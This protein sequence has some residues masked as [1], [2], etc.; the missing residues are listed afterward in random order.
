MPDIVVNNSF[1]ERNMGHGVS[2][3]YMRSLVLI[4]QSN[5]TDN[6]FGSGLNVRGGA[7]DINV[8]YS[9]I[10][11]NIGDGVNITYE[12][13]IQ[14]V[15]RS[16]ISNNQGRGIAIWFNETGQD[17]K[18]TH[19]TSVAYS[20]F[21]GNLDIGLL[22]GNFCRENFVNVSTNTFE[23]SQQAAL[24]LE[25]CWL[26]DKPIRNAHIGHN[27]FLRNQRLAISVSPAV[28]M[29]LTI[30]W[31]E[32]HE[33]RRGTLK[34]FNEDLN[35]LEILPLK[36][37][38]TENTFMYNT[39]LYVMLLTLNIRALDQHLLAT[40]NT[41]KYNNINEAYPSIISRSKASGVVCI[42]S[43]NVRIY[44]N[45]LENPES[46]HELTS[47]TLDQTSPINATFNWLGKKSENE[48]FE[49][50]FDR[51]DRYT[52]ALIKFRPFLLSDNNMDTPVISLTQKEEPDFYDPRDPSIIGGEINGNI[53]LTN[54]F[55]RVIKD[56]NVQPTGLLTIPFG[57]TLEFAEGV[58]MMI[59]G[60]LR[61][62]GS[63]NKKVRFTL[64]G[65]TEKE[66]IE[67]LII[68][69]HI[70][71]LPENMTS[72]NKT[73]DDDDITPRDQNSTYIEPDMPLK[74]VG[75]K[76]E[77]EGRLMVY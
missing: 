16:T 2:V 63:D 61:T 12:G 26:E 43:N 66:K 72:M 46:L 68:G 75:G 18:I 54:D 27:L 35:E 71:D 74:L 3:D 47:H 53:A 58:G 41:L 38:I 21:E 28:N 60:T 65:I 19:E 39:G 25:S 33:N 14:N 50:V 57:T 77:L 70:N 73:E 64:A 7:G 17:T 6:I 4:H 51:R 32:L 55:Y 31:N 9:T 45:L 37:L 1:V 5:L 34:V 20:T 29:N 24:H 10:T 30:E 52:L 22:V 36:A 8:T 42:G 76:D 11:N 40:R 48:V 62:E 49:R 59:T 67:A 13:G 23:H 44:R 69:G 15:T 56:I